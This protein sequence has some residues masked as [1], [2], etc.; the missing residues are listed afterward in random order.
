MIVLE[1]YVLSAQGLVPAHN[2]RPF[3]SIRSLSISFIRVI[4]ASNSRT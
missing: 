1:S 4:S 2:T 3:N